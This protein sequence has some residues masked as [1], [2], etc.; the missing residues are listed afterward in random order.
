MAGWEAAQEARHAVMLAQLFCLSMGKSRR[1]GGRDP[2]RPPPLNTIKNNRICPNGML[3][4]GR[5]NRR[6]QQRE[7]R[8]GGA[9]ES[10]RGQGAEG[11]RSAL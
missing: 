1:Q 3:R 9:G 2:L 7:R 6:D 10:R 5:R 4:E 11:W 8:G